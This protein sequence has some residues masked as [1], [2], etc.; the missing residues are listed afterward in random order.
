MF[1]PVPLAHTLLAGRLRPGGRAV[2]ATVGNGHDT[3]FLAR[4]LGPSGLVHGFDVQPEALAS[5]SRRLD[6]AGPNLAPV[7]LHQCGHETAGPLLDRADL[8]ELD[9]AMFNLGYLPGGDKSLTTRPDTTIAALDQ[10][11][12]RLSPTG[13]LTVVAYPGHPGGAAERDAVVAWAARLPSPGWAAWRFT[14]LNRGPGRAELI[15][16]ERTVKP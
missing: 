3:V 12:A 5:V 8:N 7:H 13:L 6:A 14:S 9:A 10:L 2:D 11:A 4:V 16:V 15:V 1:D